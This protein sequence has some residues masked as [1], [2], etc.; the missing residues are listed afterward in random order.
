MTNAEI[1]DKIKRSR[2]YQYEIAAK[3]GITEYTLCKWFREELTEEKQNQI[4]SA[5]KEIQSNS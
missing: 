4:L 3:M 2:I 1:K 5:I